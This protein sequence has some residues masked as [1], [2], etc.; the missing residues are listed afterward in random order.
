MSALEGGHGVTHND[1]RL[2]GRFRF[3]VIFPGTRAWLLVDTYQILFRG[4]G[5]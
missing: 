2:S 5:D 4:V 3:L 1:F